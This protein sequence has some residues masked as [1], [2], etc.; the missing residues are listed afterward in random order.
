MTRVILTLILC[1]SMAGSILAQRAAAPPQGSQ[2]EILDIATGE[3]TVVKHFGF[4][5]EAPEWSRDG[6]TIYFNRGGGIYKIASD[7]GEPVRINIEKQISCNNDHVVSPDGKSLAVSAGGDGFDSRI[8]VL[9]ID[10][11]MPRLVTEKAPSYLHGWSP[12]GQ[13]LAFTG[14]REANHFDIYT[15]SLDG[16]NETRLTDVPGLDDGPEFTPDGKY[17]WFCS[18][19]SGLMQ[20]WRMKADG[21]QQEQMTREEANCWFPH[22]SPDGKSIAYLAYDKDEVGP[23]DHPANKNVR[24]YVMPAEGGPSKL[25]AEIFGG[26]GSINVNS[27]SPDSKRIAYVRYDEL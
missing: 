21:S 1:F 4:R 16:Q 3:V 19:R 7:G 26:Q 8:Y 23:G 2:I 6:K 9:P 5:V 20:L 17:I 13:T 18:V 10:G 25:L 12:D 15:I 11:G 27:W 14:K 22:V 24:L